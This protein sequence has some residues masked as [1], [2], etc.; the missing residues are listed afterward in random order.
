MQKRKISIDFDLWQYELLRQYVS[1]N[2]STNSSVINDLLKVHFGLRDSVKESIVNFCI[3]KI[4]S[5]YLEM[6]KTTGYH[7]VEIQLDIQQYSLILK[8]L[9]GD[10]RFSDFAKGQFRKI[11]LKEGYVKVAPYWII[12]DAPQKALES[13]YVGVVEVKNGEKFDAPHFVFFSDV[14]YAE[15]Y[16]DEMRE[17]ILKECVKKM[18]R[19]QDIID[20]QVELKTDDTGRWIN[21]EEHM[22]G[23]IIGF[24]SILEKNDPLL[25]ENYSPPFGCLIVRD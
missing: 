2:D 8:V 11:R 24:F 20:R 19:F 5:L 18:P 23:P 14:K 12:L 1:E 9:K 15:D 25:E 16:T 3:E 6:E 10:S 21:R 7:R 22:S 4:D 17:E 13:K